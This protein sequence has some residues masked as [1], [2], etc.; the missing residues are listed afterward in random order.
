[1]PMA[2]SGKLSNVDRKVNL[3]GNHDLRTNLKLVDVPQ[4]RKKYFKDCVGMSPHRR[5]CFTK[6]MEPPKQ[7]CGTS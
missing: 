7:I 1:M 6:A 5:L 3:D 2:V 4:A